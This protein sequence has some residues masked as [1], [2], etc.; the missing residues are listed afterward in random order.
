[1]FFVLLEGIKVG[2]A[3]TGSFCTFAPT[4]LELEKIVHEGAEVV[5]IMSY[6]AYELDT[7]FGK[8][9]DL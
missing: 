2:F 5:P 4:I 9:E 7:K 8:A 3:L 6:N 1:M